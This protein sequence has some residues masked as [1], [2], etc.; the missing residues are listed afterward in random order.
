M[1]QVGDR[2]IALQCSNN[3]T[4]TVNIFG[5]GVYV[6]D[7]PVAIFDYFEIKNPK[8]QLDNGNIV[9]GYQCWWSDEDILLNRF[10]DYEFVVV[11]IPK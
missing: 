1:E 11:D 10:K 6:G 7:Y 3:D 4:K 8:I 9:W 2:V 5:H